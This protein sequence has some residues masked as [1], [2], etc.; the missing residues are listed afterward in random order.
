MQLET[1]KAKFGLVG[2]FKNIIREEGYVIARRVVT[3]W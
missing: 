1:G 3:V 2:T